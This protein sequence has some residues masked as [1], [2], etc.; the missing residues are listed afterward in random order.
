MRDQGKSFYG[1]GSPG[2]QSAGTGAKPRNSGPGGRGWSCCRTAKMVVR[3]NPGRCLVLTQTERKACARSER[4]PGGSPWKD[5]D[6]A[7]RATPELLPRG[8]RARRAGYKPLWDFFTLRSGTRLWIW[9]K[10][11]CPPLNALWPGQAISDSAAS[12]ASDQFHTRA[13]GER[14]QQDGWSHGPQTLPG[15]WGAEAQITLW[16]FL[17]PVSL[18]KTRTTVS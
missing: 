8:R 7:T 6:G 16:L 15:H 12:W 9:D 5:H 1:L 17:P 3:T 4:G 18:E 13:G 11:E 2:R 10:R 14:P